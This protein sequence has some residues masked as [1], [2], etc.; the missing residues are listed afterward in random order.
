MILLIDNYD[1]FTYNV[2]QA[3]ANLGHPLQVV[4]VRADAGEGQVHVNVERA[5]CH[6]QQQRPGELAQQHQRVPPRRPHVALP[7]GLLARAEMK[8]QIT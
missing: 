1:S 8:P 3:I 7:A 6:E 2:Y 5:D 4:R